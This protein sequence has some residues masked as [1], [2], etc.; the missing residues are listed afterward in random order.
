MRAIDAEHYWIEARF[1]RKPGWDPDQY[2]FN[3]PAVRQTDV[4]KFH[5]KVTFLVGENGA[6]KSTLVEALAAAWGLNP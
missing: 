4:L 6:G 2:P 3:L 5:P 1:E